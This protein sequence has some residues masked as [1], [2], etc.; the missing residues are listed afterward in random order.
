MP[1]SQQVVGGNS[2]GAC[3]ASYA[4]EELQGATFTAQGVRNLWNSVQF[5]PLPWYTRMAGIQPTHS[6]PTKLSA[7]LNLR[8]MFARPFL[9]TRSEL[10]RYRWFI[11][12][13]QPD[14]I[15]HREGM[16][17]IRA[18]DQS[19]R[20]IGIYRTSGGLHYV[21]TKYDQGTYWIKDSNAWEPTYVQGPPALS[22]GTL[23]GR[24]VN[25]HTVQYQYL[26]ASIV[27]TRSRL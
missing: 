1:I 11:P 22:S 14:A 4:L 13:F 15:Y 7:R 21:L 23:F 18:G 2:C 8:R 10:Y 3:A 24:Q 19:Q 16:R 26:G 9:D 20:A 25:G 17:E 5:G 6:D 12:L 27:L